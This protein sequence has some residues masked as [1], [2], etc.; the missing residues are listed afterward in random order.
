LLNQNTGN[1][2]FV[3]SA[4]DCGG[5]Q[6]TFFKEGDLVLKMDCEGCEYDAILSCAEKHALNYLVTCRSS[7]IMWLREFKRKVR[8]SGFHVKVE[9]PKYSPAVRNPFKRLQK[10]KTNTLVTFMLNENSD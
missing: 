3:N 9:R 2:S 5:I 6:F 8:K 7:I 1:S 10:K 4:S